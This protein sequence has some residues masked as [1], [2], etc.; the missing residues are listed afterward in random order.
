MYSV[1]TSQD[2]PSRV[3]AAALP[4]GLKRADLKLNDLTYDCRLTSEPPGPGCPQVLYGTGNYRFPPP[5][6]CPLHEVCVFRLAGF[7]GNV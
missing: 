5:N 3:A 6:W 7:V 4:T 2:H 1:R